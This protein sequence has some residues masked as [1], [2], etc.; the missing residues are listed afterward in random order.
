M[1]P[2]AKAYVQVDYVGSDPGSKSE[3]N[4]SIPA[5]VITLAIATNA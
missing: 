5:C 3:G 1:W 4:G 2:E